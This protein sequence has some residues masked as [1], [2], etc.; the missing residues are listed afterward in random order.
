MT[1]ATADTDGLPWASPVWFAS[2]DHR[3]FL[4]VSSPEARHS[5]N[6]GVRPDIAIVIFDS[7]QP[8]GSGQ[9]VYVAATAELVPEPD[10]D[11]GINVF[12]AV[13]EAHAGREW[14]RSD[15]EA[16]ARLRLYHAL[17][18]EHFVLGALD[19]RLAVSLA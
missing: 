15:V 8:P 7:R 1:L 10:L 14:S 18:R 6:I 12:S 17:A 5:R 19:E 3:E 16:P 4:W 13:S 2:V 9:G 11:R